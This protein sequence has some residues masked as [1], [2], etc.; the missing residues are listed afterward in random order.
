MDQQKRND[1]LW[2]IARRRA[3]F[4]WSLAAYII[5][6]IFLVGIWYFTTGDLSQFWPIW[7][8]LGWGLGLSFQYFGA[9]HGD[10]VF[11][12]EQEYEKL[13]RQHSQL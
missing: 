1:L 6:N 10:R 8:M 5:V 4:K 3:G 7:P 11:S 2:H 13:K 9:Y 12:V